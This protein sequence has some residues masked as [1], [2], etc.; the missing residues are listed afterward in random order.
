MATP[1]QQETIL[2]DY[3]EF[4]G[5]NAAIAEALRWL[6]DQPNG[7]L[8]DQRTRLHRVIVRKDGSRIRLYFADPFSTDDYPRLSGAMSELDLND[9]LSF[10]APYCQAVLLALLWRPQPRRVYQIGFA[11]GRIPQVLHHCFPDVW[12]ESTDIDEG[13]IAIAQQYFGVQLDE[14]QQVIIQDGREYLESRSS[15]TRYDFIVC[16]A[17]RGT[18]YGPYHL[19]TQEFFELCQRHLVEGGVVAL[20]LVASSDPLLL[21][22]INTLQA[23]FR[24]VYLQVSR[25]WVVFGSDTPVDTTQAFEQAGVIQRQHELPAMMVWRAGDLHPLDEC[26]DLLARYGSTTA[27]LSD[28]EMPPVIAN[29]ERDN[30]IFYN[31]ND[32]EPC[33]CGSGKRFDA[34]HGA[35]STIAQRYTDG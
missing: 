1:C 23:A 11:G 7:V 14:R 30:P 26:H 21:A 33:P 9:P 31:V 25:T 18:G 17:Y 34:C 27:T 20:N 32:D 24:H 10:P 35:K 22:K 13:V 4:S 5:S 12:I 29:L 8:Y 15:D 28:A 19:C 6:I 3:D 2:S 16:D